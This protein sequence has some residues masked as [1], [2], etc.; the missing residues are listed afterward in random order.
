MDTYN[1]TILPNQI[2]ACTG[3]RISIK[4]PFAARWRGPP[5]RTRKALFSTTGMACT[6]ISVYYSNNLMDLLG[7]LLPGMEVDRIGD[8]CIKAYES[9]IRLVLK[10]WFRMWL[11]KNKYVYNT[12][13]INQFCEYS[14]SHG[15]PIG[16]KPSAY[17]RGK[18]VQIH[19]F[20]DLYYFPLA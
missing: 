5:T 19:P 3:F 2:P 14:Y 17:Y 11:E 9:Q 1:L 18:K 12:E 15:R 7:V 13:Y 20:F 6:S 10:R 16:R 8:N 4:H